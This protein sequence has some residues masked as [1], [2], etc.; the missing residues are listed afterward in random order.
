MSK[1]DIREAFRQLLIDDA[2][3]SL[4][5]VFLSKYDRI[6]VEKLPAA[7]IYPASGSS[8]RVAVNSF[9]DEYTLTIEVEARHTSADSVDDTLEGY[10]DEIIASVRAGSPALDALLHDYQAASSRYSFDTETGDEIGSV[11]IDID[12]ILKP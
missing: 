10:A 8:E 11:A 5:Q 2:I 7:R 1:K 6:S 4:S 9:R 12:C 3:M